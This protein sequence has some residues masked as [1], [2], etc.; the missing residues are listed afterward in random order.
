M[1]IRIHTPHTHQAKAFYPLSS[2]E[3]AGVRAVFEH[4][5]RLHNLWR[6][7]TLTLSQREREPKVRLLCYSG[8]EAYIQIVYWAS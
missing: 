6:T 1:E 3:R 8:H 4:L 7:L 5:G 2:R